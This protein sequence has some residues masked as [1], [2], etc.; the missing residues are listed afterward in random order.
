MAGESGRKPPPFVV[1][2]DQPLDGVAPGVEQGG[3]QPV[4][5]GVT[6]ASLTLHADHGRS[7]RPCL[8]HLGG[9]DIVPGRCLASCS[10]GRILSRHEAKRIL[11]TNNLT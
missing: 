8:Y 1:E 9:I 7:T 2:G 10:E 4:G 5:P 11:A 3:G 6:G